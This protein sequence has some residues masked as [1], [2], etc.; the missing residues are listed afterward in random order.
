MANLRISK[1]F[2]YL[3]YGDCIGG[4]TQFPELVGTFSAKWCKF[5]DYEDDSGAGDV[6]LKPWWE[7][8][9]SCQMVKLVSKMA[10]DT[11]VYGK[12]GCRSRRGGRLA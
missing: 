10:P 7:M 1:I 9:C 2:T 5:T 4:V 12:H 3:E 6:A 11:L 8:Q